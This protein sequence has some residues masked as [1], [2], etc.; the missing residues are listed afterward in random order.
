MKKGKL[1]WLLAVVLAAILVMTLAGVSLA[2]AGGFSGSSDYGGGSSDWGS[3]SSD[4]GSSS[5]DWGSDYDSDSDG[6]GGG[7]IAIVVMVLMVAV[8]IFNSR[9]KGAKPSAASQ[10]AGARVVE[11]TGDF[12]KPLRE[13]DPNFSAEAQQERVGNMYVQMQNAWQEKQWEPIRMLMTDT[14]FN[15]FNRQ[16]NELIRL[17]Q[18]NHVERIAVLESRIVG[19]NQDDTNDVLRIL[20]KTRIVDYYTDDSTGKV[21]RGDP[22]KELF[23][24]YEWTLIRRK[25]V[26]T[27]GTAQRSYQHCPA[28]GAPMNINQS[29]KCEYCGGIVSSGEYDWVISAIRGVSQQ[30]GR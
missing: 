12:L 24:T 1:Q 21:L 29:G 15:Q 16:L 27:Q 5:S 8:F 26:K 25:G 19:Y 18:T 3:S 2:D 30:S 20:L 7:L 14:L 28:C 4:W 6:G 22:N 9:K 23:M 10:P 17:K 13:A 11:M